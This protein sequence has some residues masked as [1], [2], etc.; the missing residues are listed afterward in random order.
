MN[1]KTTKLLRFVPRRHE[2]CRLARLQ[3]LS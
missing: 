1:A 2:K 3:L